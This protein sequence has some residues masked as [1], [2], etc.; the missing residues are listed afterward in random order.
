METKRCSHCKNDLSLSDFQKNRRA[1]DGLQ[2]RC[3]ACTKIAHIACR[4][5]RGHLWSEK[6]NPWGHRS[7][8]RLRVNAATRARRAKNV[9]KARQEG[10]DYRIKNPYCHA[11]CVANARAKKLGVE[12]TLTV[13]E[14]KEIV[15]TSKNI[16]H[17][18]GR[19]ISF[20]IGSPDRISLDH[21]LPMSRGG[22]NTKENV[23]PAHRACN[24]SRLD[25]TLAE[26]DAWLIPVS[27]FRR[28]EYGRA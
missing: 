11:V 27:I 24:R 14:W 22:T 18:C 23:L 26:F 20:K 17:L 1:P 16:C 2:C 13:E 12:S 5:K 3:R 15:H 9:V 7:E 8:N 28:S 6:T 19:E 25:M 21:V 10:R 4:A